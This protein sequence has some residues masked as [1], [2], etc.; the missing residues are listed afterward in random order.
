MGGK[1]DFWQ[2]ASNYL[3]AEA[4]QRGAESTPDATAR[5]GHY[6]SCVA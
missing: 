2:I 6:H 3:C 4:C 1:V 5:A